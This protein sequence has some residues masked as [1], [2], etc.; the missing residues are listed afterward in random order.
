MSE[1][2]RSNVNNRIIFSAIRLKWKK[3]YFYSIR[4]DWWNKRI[5][6]PLQKWAR[7][8]HIGEITFNPVI[9][10]LITLREKTIYLLLE[11]SVAYC[12][13]PRGLS[14][15]LTLPPFSC[16]M[17]SV[18]SIEEPQHQQHQRLETLLLTLLW[19]KKNGWMTVDFNIVFLCYLLFSCPEQ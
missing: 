17:S 1:F 7:R 19:N 8:A 4:K 5:Y 3:T 9:V 10:P 18:L 11:L 2:F 12:V 15:T 14:S 16:S 6:F 13:D